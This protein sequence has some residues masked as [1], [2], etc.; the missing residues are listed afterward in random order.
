MESASIILVFIAMCA[1]IGCAIYSSIRTTQTPFEKRENERSFGLYEKLVY[2]G[3]AHA[4]ALMSCRNK[5]FMEIIKANEQLNEW[6]A[7]VYR[8]MQLTLVK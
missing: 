6:D 1:L 3:I 7:K 5:H 8:L 2:E 4:D